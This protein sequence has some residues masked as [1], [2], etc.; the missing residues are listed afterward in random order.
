[1][2]YRE[3]TGTGMQMALF[4][5]AILYLFLRK[6]HT[7][8]EQKKSMYFLGYTFLFFFVTFC[9]VTA[10]IIMK[11]CIGKS[12]YWRMFWL[13]PTVIV[14]AYTA[15]LVVFEIPSKKKS[16]AVGLFLLLVVVMSG[17]TLYQPEIFSYRENNYA[18]PQNVVDVCDI[19]ERDA[20]EQ[21]ITKKKLIAATELLQ[22]IRQYDAD[23]CMPYG[24]NAP[25]GIKIDGFNAENIYRI[26]TS[27]KPNWDAL[28]YYAALEECNYIAYPTN[29]DI[30]RT[31]AE[32]GF[33]EIG[34]NASY[35][36]YRRFEEVV[37]Y[38]GEWMI[39]EYGD[40]NGNQLMFY[41]MQ[42]TKG[43]VVIIDG[44]WMTDA[45]YVRGIIKGL[46]KHVDAWIVTH[47]HRD[48]AGAI[49]KIYQNLKGITIDKI[50]AVDMASKEHCLEVAPWDETEAYEIWETLDI[51]Q[52][53]YVHE[54]DTFEVG[55]LTFE[56]YNAY[57]PKVEEL[58]RDLL[59][60]GSMMFKVCGNT[61]S[62]LFC[63]DVGQAMSDY[64][65]RKY[66]DELRADY[67]QMAHHGNGGLKKSFYVNVGAKKA[68]FDSPS[69][70]MEDKS[71]AF[72]VSKNVAIMEAMGA[73]IYSFETTP[74][75]IILK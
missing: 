11:Y 30:T 60:D 5:M 63:A 43:H 69:W 12:V 74:N 66:Q 39:T 75:Q 51:K 68:F 8:E 70:L 1:M 13:L 2:F 45:K 41:T 10:K 25:K 48:H 57:G 20:K 32:N 19:I 23:I 33:E 54:G 71:G 9:P 27:E 67:L 4:F 17:D 26:M 36:V 61:Q 28:S 47:P 62:M 29:S 49:C 58:S 73:E 18:I 15:V 59:N 7:E 24:Y 14:T 56:V 52:L 72:A 38:D 37:D 3:Y 21:G 40:P 65:L 46:G 64:L 50:Y 31:L 42:D 44:G 22:Y 55:N 6:K 34:S 35:T 53:E 16:I